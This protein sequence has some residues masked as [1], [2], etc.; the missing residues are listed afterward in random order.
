MKLLFK[1]IVLACLFVSLASCQSSK[2]ETFA[3]KGFHVSDVEVLMPPQQEKQEMLR[4]TDDFAPM[5][6]NVISRYAAEYNATN[7]NAKKGYQLNVKVEKVHYKNPLQSLIIGDG[8]YV[9]GTAILTDPANGQEIHSQSFKY[10]DS[11]SVA[12]NGIS[13]AVLSVVVKKQAAEATLSKG[14]AKA[15]MQNLFPDTDLP[16]SAKSRLKGKA[17]L[18][19]PTSAISPL[20]TNPESLA[21]GGENGSSQGSS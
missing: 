9:S 4:Y 14:V 20:S 15:V 6:D 2:K 10:L 5:L 3:G 8:N 13:G 18:E 7:P 16:S 12:I 17:V 11:A 1:F 19:A 21:V